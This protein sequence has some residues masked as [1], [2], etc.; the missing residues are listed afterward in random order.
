MQAPGPPPEKR[1][2]RE[3]AR[4]AGL[5]T[6]AIAITLDPMTNATLSYRGYRYYGLPTGTPR[7]S[8]RV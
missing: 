1:P 4:T 8:A 5:C 2:I 7:R 6:G 3:G